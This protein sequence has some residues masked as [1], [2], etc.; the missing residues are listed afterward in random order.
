MWQVTVSSLEMLLKQYT[1]SKMTK[2][3]MESVGS[4]CILKMLKNINSLK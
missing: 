1:G 4:C 2:V 3:H